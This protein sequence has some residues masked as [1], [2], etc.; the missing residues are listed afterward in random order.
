[1]KITKNELKQIIKEE[2]IKEEASQ[3][4]SVGNW[5]VQLIED[6]DGHLSV[7]ANHADGSEVHDTGEDIGQEDEYAVRLTTSKIEADYNKGAYGE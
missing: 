7:Y 4:L 5:T 2:L 3:R 1:M 6:E